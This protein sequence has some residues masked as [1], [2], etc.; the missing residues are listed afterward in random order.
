MKQEV[1]IQEELKEISP[2]V[3]GIISKENPM[4]VPAG[5]F[6]SFA[7]RL[8]DKIKS[9]SEPQQTVQQELTDLS[10]VLSQAAK[11]VL[12]EVP[13]GY[14]ERFPALLM[15]RMKDTG[16]LLNDPQLNA[17]FWAAAGKAL[18][19]EVPDRF[20]GTFPQELMKRME[21]ER[22]SSAQE[23]LEILSP[24]L[25][26]IGRQMPFDAPAGYFNE[27]TDNMIGGMKAIN[28]VNDELENLSPVMEDLKGKNPYQAPAG[29]FDG[30]AA[31]LLSRVSPVQQQPAKLVSMGNRKKWM[32]YMAAAVLTGIVITGSVLLLSRPAGGGSTANDQV[33]TEL[34]KVSDQEILNFLEAHNAPVPDSSNVMAFA[35]GSENEASDLLGDVSDN[36]LQ[37]YADLY[38]NTNDLK[39][40]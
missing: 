8:M 40:N 14:F 20:F 32:R 33:H 34:S 12:F 31:N 2:L 1:T 39:S 25:S 22:S 28:F 18:P 15:D 30:F 36:E 7:E 9:S 23:E 4:D 35:T 3:A 19:Y 10:V 29:Y 16:L 6:E 17:P 38:L 26:R 21:A 27:L 37:Q 24:V 13:E 5:Y 11:S